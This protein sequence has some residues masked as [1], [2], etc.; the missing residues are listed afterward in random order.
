MA[1]LNNLDKLT[2]KIYKAGIEK[3]EKESQTILTETEARRQQML[4]DAGD[5]AAAIVAKARKEAERLT[6][7]AENELQLKGRQLISDLKSEIEGLLSHKILDAGV[8]GAFADTSFLQTA[9]L[10]TISY[11]KSGNDL[12]LILPGPMERKLGEAFQQ[13]IREKAPNLAVSFSDRLKGGFR[14]AKKSDAYQLSFSEDD[15]ITLF[16]SY[17]TEQTDKVLFSRAS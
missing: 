2:D 13:S 12:E 16:R 7:S 8:K 5:E 3:A 1:E 10:E 6:R 11:W 9:I 15:F 4:K 14:I 17:L